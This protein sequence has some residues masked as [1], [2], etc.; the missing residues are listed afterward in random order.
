MHQGFIIERNF[1]P[2]DPMIS[3]D[4]IASVVVNEF[5]KLLPVYQHLEGET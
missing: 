2:G 5:A 4:N 1:S 3:H